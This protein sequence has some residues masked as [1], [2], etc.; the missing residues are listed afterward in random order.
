MYARCNTLGQEMVRAVAAAIAALT[1]V[2]AALKL[3]EQIDWTWAWVMAPLWMTGLGLIAGGLAFVITF[4][5]AM[6][7]RDRADE[8]A[9]KSTADQDEARRP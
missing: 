9:A 2:L 6:H 3:D 5:A 1:F 4:A 7:Q 8:A